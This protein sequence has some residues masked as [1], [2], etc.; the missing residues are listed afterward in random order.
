MKWPI[1]QVKLN[2]RLLAWWKEEVFREADYE[3]KVLI[4]EPEQ[5]SILGEGNEEENEEE[6]EKRLSESLLGCVKS[7]NQHKSE[8]TKITIEDKQPWY[9]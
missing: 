9:F 2:Q 3:K 7:Q 5:G 1:L 6:K 4:C 8:L